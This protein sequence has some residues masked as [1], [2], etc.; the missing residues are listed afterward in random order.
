VLLLSTVTLIA[1]HE[2]GARLGVVTGR[3]LTG[4]IRAQH[5]TGA[6][7]TRG[8]AHSWVSAATGRQT[9]VL[10]GLTGVVAPCTV[11]L[12]VLAFQ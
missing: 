5:G 12:A 7:V 4:L 1:F 3:G 9:G 8:T 11:A 10:V 6:A 2:L